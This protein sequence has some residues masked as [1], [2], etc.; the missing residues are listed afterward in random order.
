MIFF[1]IIIGFVF[2]LQLGTK[3]YADPHIEHTHNLL[4]K[5]IKEVKKTTT[6]PGDSE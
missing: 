5:Y 2:G 6:R 3:I 1:S 4:R